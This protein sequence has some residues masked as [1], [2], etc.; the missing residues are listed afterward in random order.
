MRERVKMRVEMEEILN[1]LQNHFKIQ[2]PVRRVEIYDN[3]HLQMT[4]AFGAMVVFS[5]NG[6]FKN[7]Y[8]KFAFKNPLAYRQ[9]DATMMAEVVRRRLAM[10]DVDLPDL[11]I[12]DGG[13]HQLAKVRAVLKDHNLNINVIAMAKRPDNGPEKF[14]LQENG[15]AIC[16]EEESLLLFLRRVRDEVHRYVLTCHRMRRNRSMLK[17]SE[18][19]VIIPGVGGVRWA[20]LKEH[21]GSLERVYSATVEE[22]M[23]VQGF[24]QKIAESIV[25][26]TSKNKDN[27]KND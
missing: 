5:P 12:L 2:T 24:N 13:R 11:M 17:N 8:R 18:D 22:L 25:F 27:I 1:K 6:F 7:G 10:D 26:Y 14:Y 15:D 9:D 23:A 3:S 21:F 4:N 16:V 19:S 20:R